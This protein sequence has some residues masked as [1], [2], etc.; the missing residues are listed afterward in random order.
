MEMAQRVEALAYKPDNQ[1]TILGTHMMDQTAP[2]GCPLPSI[3]TVIRRY[4]RVRTCT[5]KHML[6]I[7]SIFFNK[8]RLERNDL[9]AKSEYYFC[10]GPKFGSQLTSDSSQL[11]IT[12]AQEDLTPLDS[13]GACTHMDTTHK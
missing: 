6:I 3:C 8:G 5:H 9:V 13:M 1:S 4:M 10:I 12:P 7:H 11:P 2:T